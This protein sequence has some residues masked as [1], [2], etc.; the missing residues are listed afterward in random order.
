[1]IVALALFALSP[2]RPIALSPYRPMIPA[3]R[4]A[5]QCA[6]SRGQSQG[7]AAGEGGGGGKRGSR[8][9]GTF[10]AI[11]PYRPILSPFSPYRPIVPTDVCTTSERKRGHRSAI[12]EGKWRWRIRVED[13]SEVLVSCGSEDAPGAAPQHIVHLFGCAQSSH[14]LYN[15]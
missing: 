11:S 2:Y 15:I 3:V 1:M 5:G 13:L 12:Q 7:G 14:L 10:D 8:A 6:C 4:V 9:G